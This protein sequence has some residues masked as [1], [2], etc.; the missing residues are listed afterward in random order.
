MKIVL[1]F[2]SS[3]LAGNGAKFGAGQ[4]GKI[5]ATKQHREWARLATLEARG[6]E[7]PL[8][9][10]GQAAADVDKA[11]IAIT[12]RFIPPNNRGDRVG[13]PYRMKAYFDGI[14]DALGVNDRRFH[15]CFIFCEPEK[16][17]RVEVYIGDGKGSCIGHAQRQPSA[18]NPRAVNK[19]TAGA[20]AT[21][22]RTGHDHN[23]FEER[24]A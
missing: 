17:G 5:K 13:Y 6:G 24:Q 22:P 11:D 9:E 10:D 19:K 18:T 4:W 1:P 12:I 7:R 16:P 14:A 15:P 3:T 2:P 21:N 20:S 23:A 8:L